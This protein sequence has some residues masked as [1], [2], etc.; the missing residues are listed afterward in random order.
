VNYSDYL[1][2]DPAINAW[3]V[4][5][6]EVHLGTDAGLNGQGI[7]GIAI[8]LNA[9]LVGQGSSSIAIGAIAAGGPIAQGYGAVALGNGAGFD[10]QGFNS[11][12]IGGSAGNFRQGTESI[13]IGIGAGGNTQGNRAVSIGYAAG[14]DFQ[15]EEA[16]AIGAEAGT[17]NQGLRSVAI[18]FKAGETSLGA[19]SVAIG[20]YAAAP[21]PGTIVLNGSTGP[22]ATAPAS[23]G[24]FVSPVAATGATGVLFGMHYNTLTHEIG[25]QPSKSF[26]IDHPIDPQRYL[27]HACLEGPEAGVYYRGESEL[28]DGKTWVDLPRY[29]SALA[30]DFTVQL[31]QISNSDNDGFARLRAGR[32]IDGRFA[33]YGDPCLFAWHVYG[34]R[35]KVHPEPFKADVEIKG[36]GPY[37]YIQ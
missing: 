4:G 24:F 6:P 22:F 27:V 20:N 35:Q 9:A 19:N 23:S 10:N 18:G 21:V 7:N 14:D 31:T 16:I 11:I 36:D 8:G 33:V 32:V 25:Y 28:V 12:G 15:G 5:G 26:V 1:F 13:G 17:L 3:K 34:L 2:W 29:V 37:K 30:T